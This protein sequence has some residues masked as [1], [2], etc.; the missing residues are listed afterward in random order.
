MRFRPDRSAFV[1]ADTNRSG[2]RPDL[3]PELEALHGEPHRDEYLHLAL[4]AIWSTSARC[5]IAWVVMR[6][7]NR[8]LARGVAA[9][10]STARPRCTASPRL[11]LASASTTTRANLHG[12]CCARKPV[13]SARGRS[14]SA[15]GHS[16]R[17]N[18]AVDACLAFDLV[19]AGFH[20]VSTFR[21]AVLVAAG[22]EFAP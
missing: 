20:G 18:R 6:C 15:C 5:R 10:T 7:T 2:V 13:L 11:R 17:R 3:V 4:R 8:G 22:T 19:Q 21:M 1:R 14:G 12:D 9:S 16:S